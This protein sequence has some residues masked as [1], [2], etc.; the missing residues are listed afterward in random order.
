MEDRTA[1]FLILFLG[2]ALIGVTGYATYVA[3]NPDS[4]FF[5]DPFEEHEE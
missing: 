4:P 5:K 1:A 2:I 3:L